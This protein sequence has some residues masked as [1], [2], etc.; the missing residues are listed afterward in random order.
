MSFSHIDSKSLT[1]FKETSFPY[2]KSSEL[3]LKTNQE[4]LS[5]PSLLSWDVKNRFFFYYFF[6]DFDVLFLKNCNYVK[7]QAKQC[8]FSQS[9]AVTKL[10]LTNNN[11]K[12]TVKRVHINIEHKQQEFKDHVQ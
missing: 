12:H 11:A 4:F 7:Q 6:N 1:T 8:F 5:V 3:T 9:R 2:I 10:S